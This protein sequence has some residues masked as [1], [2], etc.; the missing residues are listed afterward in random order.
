MSSRLVRSLVIIVSLAIYGWETVYDVVP[1]MPAESD[2]RHYYEAARLLMSGYSPYGEQGFD[3]PPLLAYIVAPISGPG[4]LFARWAWFLL[5]QASTLGAMWILYRRAQI[6][7]WILAVSVGLLAD[8]AQETF[9]LGQVTPLLVLLTALAI[10]EWRTSWALG[11]GCAL[12]LLPGATIVAL[13]LQRRWSEFLRASTVALIATV[14]LWLPILLMPGEKVHHNPGVWAGTPHIQNVSAP[15]SILRLLDWPTQATLPY[16][17]VTGN[18]P[19]KMHLSLA[20]QWAAGFTAL[21]VLIV[22]YVLLSKRRYPLPLAIVAMTAIS[23][24]ASP[25]AWTHYALLYL[26]VGAYLLAECR[27][28]GLRS[29]LTVIVAM[30]CAYTVPVEMIRLYVGAYGWGN[31]GPAPVVLFLAG[32]LPALSGITFLVLSLEVSRQSTVTIASVP[33]SAYRRG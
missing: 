24:V 11:L 32:L 19:S 17:W 6:P 2:F 3:Y 5:S 13:A 7:L 21:L 31:T 9:G 29:S 1:A 15:A 18:A 4:Y 20:H 30:L 23:V 22:A 26:P 10:T 12:K 28:R 16:H 25:L 14:G 8:A 27:P 33:Q